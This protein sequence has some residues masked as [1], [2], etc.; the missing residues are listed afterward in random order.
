MNTCS[1]PELTL[2]GG[3]AIYRQ[4]LLQIRDH[5]ASG[6]LAPGEQLPTVRAMAV[7]LA[8]NPSIVEKAYKDLEKQGF[9]T[10]N[11][12]SGTF[13][14]SLPAA[15]LQPNEYQGE[16]ERLCLE[17]LTQAARYGFSSTDIVEAIQKLTK[18]GIA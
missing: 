2:R 18:G 16:F 8:V 14:A 15:H 13:V 5:V 1:E 11:E 17:F 12:G 10:S 9:L 6:E 4:I 3:A 7:G